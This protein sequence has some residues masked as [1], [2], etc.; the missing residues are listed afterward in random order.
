MAQHTATLVVES[1]DSLVWRYPVSG[2]AE[3]TPSGTVF[4]YHT[5]ARSR[6]EEVLEVQ[7]AGLGELR[8]EEHYTHEI[9]APAADRAAVKRALSVKA[10]DPAITSAD[11]PLRFALVFEPQRALSTACDFIISKASGGRWRFE[12]VLEAAEPELDGTIQVEAYVNSVSEA[13]FLLSNPEPVASTFSA[14]FT[15]D[16]PS[17]FSVSPANGVMP[18]GPSSPQSPGETTEDGVEFVIAYAPR[19]YGKDMVGRLVIQTEEM[20]WVFEVL[21]TRPEY[22]VPE[23][24]SR[25]DTHLTDE[26][27]AALFAPK[28][29]RNIVRENIAPITRVLK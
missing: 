17:E 5:R 23:G 22:K 1:E 15:P 21:G 19:E 26:Q 20:Q 16:S 25:V 18:P 13:V 14:Y 8:G 29:R 24:I 4:K 11:V 7:L 3:A 10:L 28:P 9:I 6:L 27:E 12:I 2:I